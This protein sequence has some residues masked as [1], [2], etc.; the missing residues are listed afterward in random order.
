MSVAGWQEIVTLLLLPPGSLILIAILGFVAYSKWTWVGSLIIVASLA[1]LIALSLPLTGQQLAASLESYATPLHPDSANE[2]Q[3]RAK[4]IVILGGGRYA[5]APEFGVDTVSRLTL[6]RVRYGAYLHRQTRLPV[7]VSG[8]ST[9]GEK[10]SEAE[11]MRAVLQADYKIVPKWQESRSRNTFENAMLSS[12]L[13][14]AVRIE[15]VILVTHGW[16]MRRAVWSF[17]SA[18]LQVTPAPTGFTTLSNRQ[19]GV[20]AYLPSARGLYWSS[21]ALREYLGYWWY[22]LTYQNRDPAEQLVPQR[23]ASPPLDS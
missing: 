3:K 5:E 12:E 13:L 17:E 9:G 1:L 15:H 4:A 22:R 2:G 19:R 18:G 6:E 16:H 11:L 8:G 10:T 20:Y 23:A 7:L 21:I 14:R